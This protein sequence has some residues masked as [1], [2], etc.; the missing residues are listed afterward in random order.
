MPDSLHE[1]R[2]LN[3]RQAA[4]GTLANRDVLA[5]LFGKI[6]E[7]FERLKIY[8]SVK[9]SPAVTDALAKILAEVLSLLA[10]ATKGMKERRI[11][12]S[13]F[14]DKLLLS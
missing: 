1:P 3:L 8:T 13:I 10:L 6:E 12:G 4:S 9:P 2:N 11:S 7:F 14:C 5:N